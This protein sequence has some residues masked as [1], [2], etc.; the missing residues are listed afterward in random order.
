M[1]SAILILALLPFYNIPQNTLVPPLSV[2]QQFF[3]V[4]FLAIFFILLIL[5]G[6]PAT[7]P[8]V[9]ASQI[10]TFLY[11]FYFLVLIPSIPIIE[12]NLIS[13]CFDSKY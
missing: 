10:F 3:F 7:A 6:K 1:F 11:F 5:G 13:I 9:V 2:F 4:L 12:A 8:Y